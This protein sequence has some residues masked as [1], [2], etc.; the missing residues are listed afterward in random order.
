MSPSPG[1]PPVGVRPISRETGLRADRLRWVRAGALELALGDRV[2][3]AEDGAEWLAEVAA[4]AA[5]LVEWPESGALPT[6]SRRVPASEWP[7]PPATDGRR[8]LASLALP[9]ALLA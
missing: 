8:L 6:V 7:E 4:P 5:R 1:E 2:A 9:P 3:V